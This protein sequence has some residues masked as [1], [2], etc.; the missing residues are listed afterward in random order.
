MSNKPKKVRE[1]L[2]HIAK[3][4]G[5]PPLQAWLIRLASI[6]AALIVSALVIVVLTKENPI[7]V[8]ASMI[9][10]SFGTSRKFWILLQNIAILL[11]I[12]LAVTPAFKMKFWNLGAEGQVLVGGLASVACMFYVGDKLPNWLLL[13]VMLVVSI[14]S[15][16]IWGLIPA[17]FKSKFGTNESLFTLMMNYIAM[18]L[19]TFFINIWVPNGSNVMGLV[20]SDTKAGWIPDI[21]G[22]KYLFNIIV[23][24]VLTI[25]MFIY[26]KYSKHGYE[27]SVVGESVNTAKYCGINVK[28]VIIRTMA[29]SGAICGLAGYLLV[30]GTN[31]TISKDL[32]GGNGFTAIMVSWL[33][34]FNPIIMVVS[35][36]LIVFLQRGA[37]QIATE[38]RLNESV[39]D[40]LTGI[41]IFFLIGSE[42]FINYQ[43]KRTSTNKEDK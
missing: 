29:L 24:A 43:I 8:Y 19:V 2:F 27:L 12:A 34:K 17:Y 11:C 6:V 14:L 31:H 39:A 9:K 33:A 41:I 16:V 7:E 23:V 3:R 1:P 37:S 35:S 5:M 22:Q 30:A 38:F 20:N 32:A 25:V 4:Y 28:K 10:G 15:G 36:F 18:Q 26:L 21:F 42:F 40:I 13:V